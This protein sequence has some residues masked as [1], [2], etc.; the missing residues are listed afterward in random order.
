MRTGGRRQRTTPLIVLGVVLF[1]FP[2]AATAGPTV[3]PAGCVTGGG[4][5]VPNAVCLPSGACVFP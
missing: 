2:C 3:D 5:D 1:G 4:F